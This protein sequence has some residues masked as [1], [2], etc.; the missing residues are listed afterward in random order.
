MVLWNYGVRKHVITPQQFIAMN[1]T[2]PAKIFG[3]YP[4][5]GTLMPGADADIVIWNQKNPIIY[6][7]KNA[8]H[9]TDYNLYEGWEMQDTIQSVYLRG[10][11]IVEDGNWLGTRGQGKFLNCGDPEVI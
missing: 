5:K 9:R 7:V 4:Q 3:L 8:Q 2:N 11:L 10:K 6:G 1:C